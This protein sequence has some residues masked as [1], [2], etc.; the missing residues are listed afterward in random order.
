MLQVELD[1]L[2]PAELF[3]TK[4]DFSEKKAACNY[5]ISPSMVYFGL[6]SA[7]R[8]LWLP[9]SAKGKN[10]QHFFCNALIPLYQ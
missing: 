8:K 5:T 4:C 7:L 1:S 2:K 6:L 9:D 3:S 10:N